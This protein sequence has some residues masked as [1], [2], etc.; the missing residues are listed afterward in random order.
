M[1]IQNA[2]SILVIFLSVTLAVFLILSIM[3]L[4]KCLQIATKVKAITDKAEHLVDQAESGV[5]F[6]KHASGSL[7]IGKLLTNVFGSVLNR[8]SKKKR[9]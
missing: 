5:E 6:L 9:R 7:A 1:T 3:L 2:E 4:V 8:G